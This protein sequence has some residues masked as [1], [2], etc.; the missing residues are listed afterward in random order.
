VETK[1]T[2]SEYLFGA[3]RH[4]KTGETYTNAEVVRGVARFLTPPCSRVR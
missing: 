3:I 1:F 4:P 2:L